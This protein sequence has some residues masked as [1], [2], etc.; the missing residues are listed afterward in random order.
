M[1]ST[2]GLRTLRLVASHGG[3]ASLISTVAGAPR[4]SVSISSAS[5]LGV[6]RPRWPALDDSQTTPDDEISLLRRE[7]REWRWANAMHARQLGAPERAKAPRFLKDVGVERLAAIV[8]QPSNSQPSRTCIENLN[9]RKLF[10]DFEVLGRGG[11]G[12]VLAAT[13]V[14]DLC[15][16]ALKVVPFGDESERVTL[17]EAVVMDAMPRHPNLIQ[18]HAS[19]VVPADG[20][21]EE[22]LASGDDDA[23]S[24][25]V[26]SD[27]RSAVPRD[28]LLVLQLELCR[29]PTLHA[30]LSASRAPTG[31]IAAHIRWRWVEGL[32]AALRALHSAGFV[33]ND[34]K[35][36][37]VFCC[38]VTG[39]VKLADFGC[40][41]RQGAQ[42][43]NFG[44]TE[45]YAAPERRCASLEFESPASDIY[46]A[47]VCAAEV[48]GGFVTA[49]ER[50]KALSRLASSVGIAGAVLACASRLLPCSAEGEL[51]IRAMLHHSPVHRPTAAEVR[52]RA[53]AQAEAALLAL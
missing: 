17:A 38:P 5:A 34:V 21:W 51:L 31:S 23:S 37:N 44:G 27:R 47:G 2:T 4:G 32:A 11:F 14:H 45:L 6:D 9:L 13:C 8:A 25:S 30:S 48:W 28:R 41:A 43:F 52:E 15:R 53:H 35:P 16:Y 1:S 7:Y 40:C 33:H 24:S 12:T 36:L 39:G 26:D 22:L 46:S 50:A 49:M 20:R 42:R 29:M 3:R 18:C 10:V 19:W